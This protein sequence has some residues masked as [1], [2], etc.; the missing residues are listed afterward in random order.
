MTFSNTQGK[1]IPKDIRNN[2]TSNI[3]LWLRCTKCQSN[4]KVTSTSTRENLSNHEALAIH[5]HMSHTPKT[6]MRNY[7]Y[8]DLRFHWHTKCNYNTTVKNY[9][10][11]DEDK[12]ILKEWP[13]TNQATPSLKCCRAIVARYQMTRTAKQLQDRWK[14][15]YK[16]SKWTY[17][18]IYIYMCVYNYKHIFI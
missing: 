16:N 1:W 10:S 11:E 18:Y 7:Q 4:R 2:Q 3:Q 9:F 5:R 14:T 17:K 8:P 6:S 12:I 13:I 15:L